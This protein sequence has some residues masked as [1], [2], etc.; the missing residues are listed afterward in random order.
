MPHTSWKEQFVSKSVEPYVLPDVVD[1]LQLCGY[2]GWCCGY[3][4]RLIFDIWLGKHQL[5]LIYLIEYQSAKSS[6]DI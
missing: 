6:A 2:H 1:K 5:W 4:R 3:D